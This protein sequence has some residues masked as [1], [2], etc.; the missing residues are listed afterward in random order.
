MER[1]KQIAFQLDLFAEQNRNAIAHSPIS[2][3]VP[4]DSEGMGSQVTGAGKQERALTD[5]LMQ[6]VCSSENIR[7]AYMFSIEL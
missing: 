5:D 6:H 1:Q 3:G 2:Q 4:E 7:K